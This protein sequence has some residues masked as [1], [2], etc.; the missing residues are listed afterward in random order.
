M[1]K[2][3]RK[4][5]ASTQKFTEIQDIVDD[6]VILQSGEAALV[7]EVIATNFA[8]QSQEEQEVKILSYG[9]LLNSLSF[10]IQILIVSKQLDISS[11]LKQLEKEAAKTANQMLSQQISLYKDL[12]SELV[13]I[14]TVLDKK[15]YIVLSFSPL[16][17]GVSGA[18]K[19]TK[20]T[21]DFNVLVNEAKTSL[22]SKADSLMSEVAR[23]NLRANILQRDELIKLFYSIYN[24]QIPADV[25]IADVM[26][27]PAVQGKK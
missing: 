1:K 14:N 11:Y 23:L 3:A 26:A 10:P 15:F 6:V 16:E 4:V 9:S 25:R 22:H 13:K 19:S 12:V 20:K 5:S 24:G 27:S 18:G 21:S 8:L 2:P 7:V 17:K